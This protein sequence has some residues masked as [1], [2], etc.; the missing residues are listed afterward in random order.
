MLNKISKIILAAAFIVLIVVGVL[1]GDL[2]FN[3]F[4][5]GTL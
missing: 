4:Q 3:Q 1:A 5:S 2:I